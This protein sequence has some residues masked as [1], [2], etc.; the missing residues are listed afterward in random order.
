MNIFWKNLVIIRGWISFRDPW[1]FDF[2]RRDQIIIKSY[3]ICQAHN[4][5]HLISIINLAYSMFLLSFKVL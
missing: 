3:K 5:I 2:I 1:I 4:K